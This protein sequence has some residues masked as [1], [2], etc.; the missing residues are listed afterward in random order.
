MSNFI[1]IEDINQREPFYINP[2]LISY[3]QDNDKLDNDGN[4]LL[5]IVM[6]TGKEIITKMHSSE[7]KKLFET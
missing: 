7:F 3:F 2:A 4:R 6:N 1:K 5:T